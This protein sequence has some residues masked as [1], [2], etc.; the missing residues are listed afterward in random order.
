GDEPPGGVPIRAIILVSL[1]LVGA[2]VVPATVEATHFTK[3][4]ER[5]YRY[6]VPPPPADPQYYHQ[7]TFTV[8]ATAK[9]ICYERTYYDGYEASNLRVTLRDGAGRVIFQEAAVTAAHPLGE[10]YLPGGIVVED[11]YSPGVRLGSLSGFAPGTWTI[12][13]EGV[14]DN[15]ESRIRLY[16]ITAASQCG[17]YTH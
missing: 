9:M 14:G 10:V 7:A 2:L 6:D 3:Y 5:L 17:H 16:E 12:T 15:G 13:F 8:P 11:A 1:V 4:Y